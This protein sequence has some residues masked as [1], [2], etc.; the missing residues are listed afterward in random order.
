MANKTTKKDYF[1]QVIALA[2]EVGNSDLI[3]FAQHEI[4]LLD[5]KNATRS[6]KPS[7]AQEAN[8]A[9]RVK[10]LETLTPNQWYTLSGI[11]ELIPELQASNGTQK[12]SAVV[13]PL[14]EAGKLERMT[15]KRVVYLK[16]A[17]A[18]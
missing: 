12:T 2:T 10:I 7:K 1:N 16:L 18:E 4:E 11:K 14:V 9:I 3:A 6:N 17:D 13:R 5:R 15:E 8:E